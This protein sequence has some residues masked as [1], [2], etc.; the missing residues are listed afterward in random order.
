MEYCCLLCRD[1]SKNKD[2][3][4]DQKHAGLLS[5][6]LVRTIPLPFQGVGVERKVYVTET[7]GKNRDI[8]GNHLS[9]VEQV[10]H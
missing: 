1:F 10:T 3:L 7:L 2:D 9:F 8:C 6:Y 5:S 4:L